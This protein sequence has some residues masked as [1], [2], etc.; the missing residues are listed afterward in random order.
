MSLCTLFSD[1]DAV[2]TPS[3]P[4]SSPLDTP[5]LQHTPRQSS[6]RNVKIRYYTRT[7]CLLAIRM[8][9]SRPRLLSSIRGECQGNAVWSYV[10]HP[11]GW[12]AVECA[13]ELASFGTV[14]EMSKTPILAGDRSHPVSS[15][16]FPLFLQLL[17]Q[18]FCGHLAHILLS[19]SDS[20]QKSKQWGPE[21]AETR[22][23][24]CCRGSLYL[25][26]VLLCVRLRILV[27]STRFM[28]PITPLVC[29]A[30]L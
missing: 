16:R 21:L 26:P 9:S 25:R 10:G 29:V 3:R 12:A 24:P 20:R 6:S 18:S 7:S 30:L 28:N 23:G 13:E 2:F 14:W 22:L 19:Y 17:R 27:S 11:R 5:G 1:L 4:L 8:P 15:V